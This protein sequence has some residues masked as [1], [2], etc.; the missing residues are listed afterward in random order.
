MKLNGYSL[1]QLIGMIPEFH[2]DRREVQCSWD[3]KGKVIRQIM[4]EEGDNRIET[5]E[6]VKIYNDKGWVLVLPDAEQPVCRVISE[7]YSAEFAQELSAIYAN[8][9]REISRSQ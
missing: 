8:K 2:M 6:G 4:Q 1:S 3:A 5:L 9:I 7:G